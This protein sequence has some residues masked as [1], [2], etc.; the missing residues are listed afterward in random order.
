M[1]SHVARLFIALL[2]ATVVLEMPAGAAELMPCRTL[3]IKPLRLDPTL[4]TVQIRC[5]APGQSF[6]FPTNPPPTSGGAILARDLGTVGQ[7]L[8]FTHTF[9]PALWSSV[10]LAGENGFR[11]HRPRGN[12]PLIGRPCRV[13]LGRRS[14]SISCLTDV[15]AV[16]APL[17][18]DLGFILRI[19][20]A[21]YCG[22]IG[23]VE[24][25]NDTLSVQRAK[26]PA[27]SACISSF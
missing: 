14:L 25:R 15:R 2:S 24:K 13:M 8:A 11:F 10:G 5:Q 20:D 22:Q 17:V 26:A 19:G 6:T 9:E 21:E 1:F 4:A 7:D 23:G 16:V 27:P 18:G 12:P 3:A